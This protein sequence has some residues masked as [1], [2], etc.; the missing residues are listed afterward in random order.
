MNRLIIIATVALLLNIVLVANATERAVL[1]AGGWSTGYEV[2]AE[3]GELYYSF[4]KP[5]DA[6]K[7]MA[8]NGSYFWAGENTTTILKFDKTGTVVDTFEIPE[9]DGIFGITYDG[10]YLWVNIYDIET[11]ENRAYHLD[12]N[13]SQI[14]PDDFDIH[15]LAYDLAWDGEYL[16]AV[17]G[18]GW[19]CYALCYDV[20]TGTL[21]TS[22]P[23]GDDLWETETKCIA[24]DGVYIYTIGW[25]TTNPGSEWWIY[26]YSETGDLIDHISTWTTNWPWGLSYWEEG[27]TNVKP[28]S[29]G[30]IKAVYK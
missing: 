12:L 16:W 7:G 30:E 6:G 14:P 26:K 9:G 13:G 24:S 29:F 25:E 8:Y 15:Y 3:T 27:I 2:D 4:E 5:E 18:A 20:N 11:E 19:D 23:V 22:F 1:W 28:A 21:I 17:A 10:E